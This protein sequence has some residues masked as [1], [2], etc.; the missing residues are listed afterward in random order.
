M[1]ETGKKNPVWAVLIAA[2]AV[3]IILLVSHKMLQTQERIE[4]VQA[5]LERTKLRALE[6]RSMLLA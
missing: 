4:T 1:L 6:L 5:E 3:V 2:I